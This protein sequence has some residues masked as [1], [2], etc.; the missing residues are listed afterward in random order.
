[1]IL[2][3][4]PDEDVVHTWD[5]MKEVIR[6]RSWLLFKD[7]RRRRM[8]AARDADASANYAFSSL[9]VATADAFQPLL[10]AALTQAH[11]AGSPPN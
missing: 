9:R 10:Q 3:L 7:L 8:Q 4:V 6:R 2:S 1:L 11:A 5:N